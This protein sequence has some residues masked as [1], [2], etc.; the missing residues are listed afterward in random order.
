MLAISL[1][2]GSSGNCYYVE[3]AGVRLLL[4]AGINGADAERRLSAHGREI[5]KADALIISHDH[6]D[7]AAFAGV[8]QRKYGLPIY[9]TRK[10]FEAASPHLGRIRSVKFFRS[11]ETLDFGPVQVYTLP[12]PHDGAD[13][14]VFVVS[15]G[16]KRFGLLTDLGHAFA[17]LGE[18]VCTL[19]G[20]FLE[21]NYDP[22]MLGRGPYPEFL[23]KR[24][25]GPGGHISNSESARLLAR[26]G[27]N[28]KW[29]CLAHLSENNNTPRLALSTHRAIVNPKLPLHPLSR[30]LASQVFRI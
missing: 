9:I 23:K 14:S 20:V 25:A 30:Y 26:F 4:D 29:A 15:S 19:N 10:T 17:G 8:Y 16:G 21:S 24:I 13:G 27:S 3:S 7:H 12:T 18:L 2:S 1:Q 6:S 11:G 28:L 22:G 5:R